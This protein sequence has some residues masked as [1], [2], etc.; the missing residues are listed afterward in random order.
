MPSYVFEN[1]KTKERVEIVQ[2]INESHV[3]VDS[4]GLEWDRVFTLPQV[5]IDAR[6]PRNQSEFLDVTAKKKGSIGDMQDLS[7]EISRKR[8]QEIGYDP[9][10][11]KFFEEYSASRNGKKH[12]LDTKTV[13]IGNDIL[14]VSVTHDRQ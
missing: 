1:P 12:Q 8:A 11:S 10:K 9:V 3:F 14:K 2:S 5:A 6:T 4:D 7:A 13:N